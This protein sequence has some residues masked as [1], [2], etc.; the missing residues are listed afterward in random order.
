M[1]EAGG[2]HRFIYAGVVTFTVNRKCPSTKG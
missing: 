2:S 1:I